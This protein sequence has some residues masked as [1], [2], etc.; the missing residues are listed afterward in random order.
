MALDASWDEELEAG[1]IYLP[2]H[3]GAGTPGCVA[4]SIDV[5]ALDDRLRGMQVILDIDD[6]D[7]VIG[8]E[9]LR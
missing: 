6:K 5:F 7:R 1:Y 4:R 9:V 2:D 8:I 3:P